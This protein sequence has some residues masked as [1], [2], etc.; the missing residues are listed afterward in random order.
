MPA[1]PRSAKLDAMG[2]IAARWPLERIVRFALLALAA[3][4]VSI[5]G[6]APAA[7]P[8]RIVA[9]GDLH[10]DY[11]AWQAIARSAGVMDTHGHWAGGKSTLVQL[12]DRYAANPKDKAI[13]LKYASALQMDGRTDQ[14]CAAG[15]SGR[16]SLRPST[17]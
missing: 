9:V 2:A 14:D 17:P 4:V 1:S 11:Q 8:Q 7:Q 13:S 5:P 16:A 15:C 10:G 3:L 12:G 6:S